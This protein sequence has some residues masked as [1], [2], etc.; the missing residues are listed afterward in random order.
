MSA[1]LVKI[2]IISVIIIVLTVRQAAL[3][4]KMVSAKVALR[5]TTFQEHLVQIAPLNAL[6]V[7]QL[8]HAQNVT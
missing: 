5:V 4:A 7:I 1:G 8:H 3:V 2:I 6:L